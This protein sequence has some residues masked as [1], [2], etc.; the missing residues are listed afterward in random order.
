[1]EIDSRIIIYLLASSIW[2]CLL[3]SKAIADELRSRSWYVEKLE[4]NCEILPKSPAS[5]DIVNE[6]MELNA[7]WNKLLTIVATKEV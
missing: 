1:M 7:R 3:F 2:N 4:C 5:D 6:V